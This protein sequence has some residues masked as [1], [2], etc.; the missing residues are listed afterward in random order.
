MSRCLWWFV[1]ATG[2][3]SSKPRIPPEVPSSWLLNSQV[4]VQLSLENPQWQ[5]FHCLSGQP[6]PRHDYFCREFSFFSYPLGT[7]PVTIYASSYLLSHCAP[8]Q[9]AQLSSR[10]LPLGT[11]KLLLGLPLI[12]RVN[13]PSSF[14]RFS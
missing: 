9:R 5:E 4:F 7:F 1:M 11:S 13:K 12:S 3:A 2:D 6:S 10:Y 14:S 8:Q